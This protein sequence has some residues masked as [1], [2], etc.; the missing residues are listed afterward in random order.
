MGGLTWVTTRCL[1]GTH[2]EIASKRIG[3]PPAA[4]GSRGRASTHQRTL[5]A[6]RR[7]VARRQPVGSQADGAKHT[8]E[9]FRKAQRYWLLVC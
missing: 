3:S 2:V 9:G 5:R 7:R 8:R 6:G 1:P 4:N